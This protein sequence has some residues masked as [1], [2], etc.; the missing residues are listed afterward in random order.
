MSFKIHL[1]V[2]SLII[3]IVYGAWQVMYVNQQPIIVEAPAQ[4]GDGKSIQIIRASW[5]LNCSN[6][7]FSQNGGAESPTNYATENN[8]APQIK[9]NNILEVVG[10]LCNG[11]ATCSISPTVEVLGPDPLPQCFDKQLE[12][13]YRCFAFD[14]PWRVRGNNAPLQI[15]CSKKGG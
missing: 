7:K 13:E 3:A 1:L 2:V 8:P 9:E 5:G 6:T 4:Q 14:R 15:D 11:Q 12:I 10:K